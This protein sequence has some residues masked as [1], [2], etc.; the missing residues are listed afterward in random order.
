MYGCEILICQLSPLSDSLIRSK[1]K[2]TVH[3]ASES[4]SRLRVAHKGNVLVLC[5]K[6]IICVQNAVFRSINP[7]NMYTF[8]L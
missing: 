5:L 4:H 3:D 2:K 1:I 8:Q 7:Q 6:F